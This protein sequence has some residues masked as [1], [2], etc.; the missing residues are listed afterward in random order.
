MARTFARPLVLGLVLPALQHVS[1]EGPQPSGPV[2]DVIRKFIILPRVGSRVIPWRSTGYERAGG[3]RVGRS[4]IEERALFSVRFMFHVSCFLLVLGT[5][6]P[7]F[8]F[9]YP[10]CS[11][12][13]A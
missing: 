7:P 13:G 12:L 5:H 3:K 10:C 9:P 4:V 2:K 8:S 1:F 11:A 6:H